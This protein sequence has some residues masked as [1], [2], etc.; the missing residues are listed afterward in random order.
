[1]SDQP[2]Q[3]KPQPEQPAPTPAQTPPPAPQPEE[4]KREAQGRVHVIG[5]GEVVIDGRAGE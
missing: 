2:E 3:P 5:P 4:P 1:M